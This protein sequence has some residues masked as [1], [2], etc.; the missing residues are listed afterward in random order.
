MGIIRPG[1]RVLPMMKSVQSKG[2]RRSA[3]VQAAVESLEPRQLFAVSFDTYLIGPAPNLEPIASAADQHGNG[4][5]L[6]SFSGYADF[7][8]AAHKTFTVNGDG[9]GTS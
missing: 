6:S 5:V 1:K 9:S 3:V 8:P 4:Y 7:N 2:R